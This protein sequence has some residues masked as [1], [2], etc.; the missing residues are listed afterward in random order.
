MKKNV[1]IA[2]A[3]LGLCA[4]NN[5]IIQKMDYNEVPAVYHLNIQA[6][7]DPLTKAVT[8]GDDGVTITTGFEVTDCIYVYNETKQAFARAGSGDYIVLHPSFIS[9][10]GTS[11]TLSG[12]LSFYT[13]DETETQWANVLV[14]ETDTY[15]LYYQLNLPGSGY[16]M[17]PVFYYDDQDGGIASV[18]GLDFAEATGVSM[19]LSGSTLTVADGVR[20]E[21]LQ[22]MFRQHLSFTKDGVAI[23]PGTLT[24]IEVSTEN[25][26]LIDM[27]SPTDLSDPYSFGSIF[28]VSP[29]LSADNDVYLSL[30]FHY[31]EGQSAVGDKLIL[32]AT[33]GNGNIYQCSK[34]V[35]TSGFVPSMYYYGSMTLAWTG[36]DIKPTVTRGDGGSDIV[37]G[38][39]GEYVFNYS[40]EPDPT[41]FTISGNS[42]GYYFYVGRDAIITLAGD[43]TAG[44]VPDNSNDSFLYDEMGG[45][46]IILASDYTIDCKNLKTAIWADWGDLT[47]ETNTGSAQTLTVIA[48]DPDYR[49]LYGENYYD[50]TVDPGELAADDFKVE[51]TSTTPGPDEDS[52]GEPDYFTWVY[53]VTPVE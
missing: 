47:L 19:T 36:Q 10:S 20:L 23:D 40:S 42:A 4:C 41:V 43:G 34:S 30:A 14:E 48:N 22:S 37:P 49:G 29:V 6:G 38:V 32:K 53:T 46:R 9:D 12:D 28:L 2:F 52:N 3:A 39:D 50:N 21:N 24:S 44:N 13:W 5:E 7:F 35:P 17:V 45:F 18:S 1:Y 51:L 27:Y 16:S 25:G 15:A 11:C 33:D 31:D 26:T 8:F